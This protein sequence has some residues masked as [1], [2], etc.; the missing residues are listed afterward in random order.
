MDA[1]RDRAARA[2]ADWRSGWQRC[3]IS[4]L[5]RRVTS[6][7]AEGEGDALLEAGHVTGLAARARAC[8]AAGEAARGKGA[9]AES[10][11]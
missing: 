8:G 5:G 3:G 6:S 4:G 2:E 11:E 7:K 9:R 10:E 1:P